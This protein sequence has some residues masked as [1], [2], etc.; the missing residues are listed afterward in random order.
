MLGS[1]VQGARRGFARAVVDLIGSLVAVVIALGRPA[2]GLGL[3]AALSA[4]DARPGSAACPLRGRDRR[5]IALFPG[6]RARFRQH[7]DLPARGPGA[8]ISALG[9]ALAGLAQGLVIAALALVPFAAT[10]VLPEVT[11]EIG[12][13]QLAPRLVG[14][15][16]VSEM[17][18]ET[19]AG[20]PGSG[21]VNELAQPRAGASS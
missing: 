10:P 3:G 18:V 7:V 16:V 5:R 11:S 21:P 1:V 19:L 12:H 20:H 6:T 4:A 2:A 13:S 14:W 17:F 9:G 8:L 15:W